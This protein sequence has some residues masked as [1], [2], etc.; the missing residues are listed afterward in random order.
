V[1][2]GVPASRTALGRLSLEG[3]A[4]AWIWPIKPP[5]P[6]F[7][8]LFE[9]GV[10]YTLFSLPVVGRLSATLLAGYGYALMIDKTHW[11]GRIGSSQRAA[12]P[13]RFDLASPGRPILPRSDFHSFSR[14]GGPKGLK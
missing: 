11:G 13:C 14:A 5:T 3:R 8:P 7:S 2:S 9:L 4:G 6:A 12:E 1:G 10:K